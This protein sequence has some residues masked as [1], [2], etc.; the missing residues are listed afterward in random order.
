MLVVDCINY[1]VGLNNGSL[2]GLMN[3]VISRTRFSW[4]RGADVV[5]FPEYTWVNAVQ[6]ASPMLDRHQL[7]ESFWQ[8]AFPVLSTELS[9][10]GKTV[11]L[12]SVP[13]LQNGVLYNTSIIFSNGQCVFQDKLAMTPWEDEFKGGAEIKIF[14]IGHLNCAVLICLDVEMPDLAQT[15]KAYGKLDVLFVPSAT[16]TMMGVER[17]ARCATARSVELGCAV[18]TSGLTGGIEGYDFIDSNYGRAA[19]Y[20]PSLAGFEAVDRVLEMNVETQGDTPHRFEISEEVFVNSKAK[21]MST[22]PAQ[23]FVAENISLNEPHT[24]KLEAA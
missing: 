1:N 20:L 13:R 22:N 5:M 3:D 11:I 14:Q 16:E 24:S 15:L 6:Y 2:E 8:T 23:I 7:A 17:I 18:I 19:L 9:V 21:I 10:S 4:E 12:G